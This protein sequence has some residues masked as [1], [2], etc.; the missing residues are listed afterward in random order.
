[1]KFFT[2]KETQNIMQEN[3]KPRKAPE[4]DQITGRILKEVPRKGVLHL[5]ITC[6]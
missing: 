2:P 5:T 3:L 6:N 1:M 4:F